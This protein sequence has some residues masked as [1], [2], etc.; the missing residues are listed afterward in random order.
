MRM[1]VI[2][3]EENISENEQKLK[4]KEEQLEVL[5]AN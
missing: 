1:Q 2:R 4:Q 3:K 5:L